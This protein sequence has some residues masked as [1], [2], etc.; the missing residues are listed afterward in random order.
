VGDRLRD[1]VGRGQG[2]IAIGVFAGMV[3]GLSLVLALSD[4]YA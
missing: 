3:V 1:W 4:D 2:G